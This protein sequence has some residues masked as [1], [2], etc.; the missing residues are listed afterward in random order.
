MKE[1][2]VGAKFFWNPAIFPYYIVEE[3]TEYISFKRDGFQIKRVY[4]YVFEDAVKRNA[5]EF[6]G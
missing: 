6:V 1:I 2:K 4:R 5:I 3:D